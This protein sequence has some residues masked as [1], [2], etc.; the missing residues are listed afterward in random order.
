MSTMSRLAASTRIPAAPTDFL[1]DDIAIDT[2][3]LTT[4]ASAFQGSH[5]K[6]A[7]FGGRDARK[8]GDGGGEIAHD[9]A[10]CQR[11]VVE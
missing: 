7:R 5:D 1:K 8:P 11:A 3:T 4:V 6:S 2:S 9:M 10:D